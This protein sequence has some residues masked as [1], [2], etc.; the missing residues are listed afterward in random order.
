ME[1]PPYLLGGS[2]WLNLVNTRY[3]HNREVQDVLA[4]IAGTRQWLLDN[5]LIPPDDTSDDAAFLEEARHALASLRELCAEAI[6]DLGQRSKLSDALLTK[7]NERIERLSLMTS[8]TQTEDKLALRHDGKHPLDHALYE[9]I[10]SIV[11][12]LATYT[13]DRVRKCE[14]EEC[15]LHFV[16]ISKSGKRRWCRMEVCGNRHKAAEFYAKKKKQITS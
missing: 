5:Q 16:D 11:D 8:L 6:S 3:M 1:N 7:F 14:H 15:I 13:A 2:A 12:T 9:I 10:R 4:D